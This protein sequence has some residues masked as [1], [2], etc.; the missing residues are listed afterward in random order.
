MPESVR[1]PGELR[2]EGPGYESISVTEFSLRFVTNKFGPARAIAVGVS[3]PKLAP[4]DTPI[5]RPEATATLVL[6]RSVQDEQAVGACGESNRV[7]EIEAGTRDRANQRLGARIELSNR[8]TRP[9]GDEDIGPDGVNG[10][11]R[12]ES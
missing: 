6:I 3:N 1:Q 5:K 10:C 9:V 2:L 7:G 12:V 8:I 11:R 4:D